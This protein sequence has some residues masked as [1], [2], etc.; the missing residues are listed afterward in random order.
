[1]VLLGQIDLSSVL[2]PSADLHAVRDREMAG[3]PKW[4]Q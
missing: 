1:M 4:S 3:N 2:A